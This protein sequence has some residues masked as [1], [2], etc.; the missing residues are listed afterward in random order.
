MVG[1]NGKKITKEEADSSMV[2]TETLFITA[3]IDLFE[4]RDVA[5]VDLPGA[6]L[7]TDS[8]PNNC[9]VHMAL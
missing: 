5:N 1:L 7:N 4:N 9:I 3:T 2:V 8:D 6:F